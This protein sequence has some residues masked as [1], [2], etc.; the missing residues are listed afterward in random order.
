MKKEKKKYI[1]KA[2]GLKKLQRYCA[3]QDR[4]HQEVRKK[5][6][7]LGIYG[8]DLE[9]II[10]DLIQD[11]FLNEERF[12]KSYA[13]GKFRVKKWGKVR[14]KRELKKR[15]ISAYCIKKGLKEI[16]SDDYWETLLAVI[17]KKNKNLKVKSEYIRKNRLAL[18]AL[19]KG[20]ETPLI[21]EAINSIFDKESENYSIEAVD[22]DK[23]W[24]DLMRVVTKKNRTLRESNTYIRKNKI[25]QHALR[26]G[27]KSALIWKAINSIFDEN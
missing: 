12:A 18:H 1:S 23:D 11:N 17:K 20:Y 25:A 13:G 6:I 14:I 3:Y 7:A 10:V 24:E 5:L 19:Q 27:Y 9:N 15:N 4:C 2:Q 21:W 8:D 22:E 26:K 16:D